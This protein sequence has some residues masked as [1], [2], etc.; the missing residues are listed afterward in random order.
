M[1]EGGE[2]PDHDN[3]NHAGILSHTRSASVGDDEMES[4]T[5]RLFNK[6]TRPARRF[7][8]KLKSKIKPPGGGKKEGE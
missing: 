6:A 3:P 4:L 8:Q 5:T 1:Q 2:E 7:G